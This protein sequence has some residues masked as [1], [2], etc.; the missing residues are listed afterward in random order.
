MCI[1]GEL[2]SVGNPDFLV[3]PVTVRFDGLF[4]YIEF[5]SDVLISVSIADKRDNFFL[6]FGNLLRLRSDF[7]I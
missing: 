4:A 5:L 6:F 7:C 2:K 3:N 1:K